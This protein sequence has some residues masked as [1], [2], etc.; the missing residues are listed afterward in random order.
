MYV[1]EEL[2]HFIGRSRPNDRARFDLL[3]Q[4]IREG[5]LRPP[6]PWIGAEVSGGT[7]INPT[8]RASANAMYTSDAVCFCDIPLEDLRIH[9]QKYSRFGLAFRK[10][11]LVPRGTRP[12]WYIP[13]DSSIEVQTDPADSS[14]LKSPNVLPAS[15]VFDR[16]CAAIANVRERLNKITRTSEFESF[17]EILHSRIEFIESEILTFLKFFDTGLGDEDSENYYM[18]REWRSRRIIQFTIQDLARVIVPF[19]YRSQFQEQCP[20]FRGAISDAPS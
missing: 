3:L 6:S 11:F 9:T 18:E 10:S 17:F 13:A 20:E 12:V 4:I 16:E 8:A 2:T 15:E 14:T 1:C 19:E 5:R 7:Y